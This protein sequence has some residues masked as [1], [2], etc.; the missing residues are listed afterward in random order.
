VVGVVGKGNKRV[1][2][3]GVFSGSPPHYG[4]PPREGLGFSRAS[5]SRDQLRYHSPHEACALQLLKTLS[6]SLACSR[7]DLSLT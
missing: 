3:S 5:R 6:M 2:S 4:V 1:N 7:I